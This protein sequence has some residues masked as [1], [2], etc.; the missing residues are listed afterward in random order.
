MN[1]QK[2]YKLSKETRNKIRLGHLGKKH[3]DE[4]R[5]KIRESLKKVYETPEMRQKMSNI[6]KHIR[7]S[8]TEEQKA[9]RY[10][11]EWRKKLS[12]SNIGENSHRWNGGTTPIIDRILK[13]FRYRIWRTEI[14]KRDNYKCQMCRSTLKLHVH[15]KQNIRFIIKKYETELK[16][17]NY[18]IPELWDIS[19]GITLCTP[20]HGL[21]HNKKRI[22]RKDHILLFLRKLN[23]IIEILPNYLQEELIQILH[24]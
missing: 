21:T 19:N 5:N 1:Q 13:N 12:K 16:S 2:S 24:E 23:S 3:S 20:C 8:L 22:T 18:E 14:L 9:I 11:M 7:A 17:Y 4:T 15:H 6:A 10:G